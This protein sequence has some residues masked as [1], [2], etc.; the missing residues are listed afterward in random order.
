MHHRK[1]GVNPDVKAV[2]D[3]LKT[4]DGPSREFRSLKRRTGLSEARLNS[5]LK[6][7]LKQKLVSRVE[8]YDGCSGVPYQYNLTPLG[9]QLF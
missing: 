7:M 6:L 1:V 5:V 9:N 2:I 3:A 4:T 8:V